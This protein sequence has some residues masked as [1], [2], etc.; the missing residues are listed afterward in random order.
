MLA[1]LRARAVSRGSVRAFKFARPARRLASTTAGPAPAGVG[2]AVAG[3]LAVASGAAGYGLASRF[4]VV[5]E[6]RTAPP[7]DSTVPTYGTNEDYQKAIKELKDALGND[8]DRVT[9]EEG[10]LQTHGFVDHDPHPGACISILK[11]YIFLIT[12]G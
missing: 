11:A 1:A 2:Y 8:S 7:P 12:L 6:A 10:D 3:G 9:T 4:G 5:A